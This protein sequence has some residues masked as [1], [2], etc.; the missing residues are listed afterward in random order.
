VADTG[1]G[2]R[3]SATVFESGVGLKNVR[4]RLLHLYGPEYA[5]VVESKT[6]EG[7]TVTLRIPLPET[8]V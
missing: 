3:D 6:G 7:T 1:A 5:P 4:D 2:V 8:T